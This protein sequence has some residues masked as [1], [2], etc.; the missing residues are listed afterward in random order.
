MQACEGM[1]AT[2]L[3]AFRWSATVVMG[4]DGMARNQHRDGR[5]KSAA[6]AVV[7]L[8]VAFAA[9][10][11]ERPD[12]TVETLRAALGERL[13]AD[14]RLSSDGAT[15]CA[16]CH[17]P[18]R[19]F[20]DGRVVAAGS[21]GRVGPRNTPSLLDVADRRALGWDGRE[22]NLASQALKPLI[23][24]REHGL[25]DTQALIAFVAADPSYREAFRAAFAAESIDV[26]QV[27]AALT[28]YLATLR[29]GSAAFDRFR[30]GDATALTPA[31]QRGYALFIGTAGCSS[32]HRIEGT[33]PSFT[34][35][36]Y[37]R[38]GVG[39]AAIADRLPDLAQHAARLDAAAIDPALVETPE[40]AALGRFLAT[41]DPRDIAAY[42]TPGLR[43]VELTSPYFHDGSAAT[44]DDAVAQE[45]YYHVDRLSRGSGLAPGEQADLTSFL[46]A[47]TDQPPV[48]KRD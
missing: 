41:K 8:L 7:A 31:Q 21:A 42:R 5:G 34:D 30:H 12:A 18:D 46:R 17:Q 19:A 14:R 4:S 39:L 35:G 28:A 45:L 15:A 44:L 23:D 32:C 25:R 22:S 20:T 36:G 3:R 10:A 43:N 38:A 37:H 26:A 48:A 24:P 1:R 16:S 29:S 9:L 47:L 27:G 2:G 11:S 33:A 40:L 6:T 13:F